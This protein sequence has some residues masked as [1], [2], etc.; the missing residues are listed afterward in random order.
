VHEWSIADAVIRT[1]EQWAEGRGRVKRIVIGVPSISFLDTDILT[2]AFDELKVGT[3]LRD[4]N[5]Q[6]KIKEQTFTCQLCGRRFTLK[7]VED[8]V[9]EVRSEFGE[10]YPLHLIPTLSPSFIKCPSCGSRD[11]MVDNQDVTVEEVIMDETS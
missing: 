5:L 1:V 7:D 2:Q 4:A 3:S 11:V 9:G 6:V 10:E 8:Q